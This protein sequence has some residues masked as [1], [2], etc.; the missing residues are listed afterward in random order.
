[1]ARPQVRDEE[2][3]L[4]IWSVAVNIFIKKSRTT[5]KGLYSSS[6]VGQ[7]ANKSSQYKPSY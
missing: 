1:M 6:A 4:Q 7:G 2:E 5:D 3:V